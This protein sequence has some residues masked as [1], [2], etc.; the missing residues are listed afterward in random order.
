MLMA[1][2]EGDQLGPADSAHQSGGPWR[3]GTVWEYQGD[4]TGTSHRDSMVKVW[5][6]Y[7]NIEGTPHKD[8]VDTEW[9]Y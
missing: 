1:L 7:G 9:E 3:E 8:T 5:G 2:E 4:I 6:Q